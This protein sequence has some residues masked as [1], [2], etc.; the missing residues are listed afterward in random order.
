MINGFVPTAADEFTI[1]ETVV[2][3]SGSFANVASGQRLT[4]VDGLGSFLVNYGAGSPFDP[5]QIVLSSFLA[6]A[7][8][9]DYNHSGVVDAADYVIWRNGGSP[10]STQSGYNL[11]KTNF[12][13]TAGSG[14]AAKVNAAVPEATTLVLAV[15]G[16]LTLLSRRRDAVS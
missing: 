10:D 3:I 16:T 6:V 2:S 7:V 1:L 9:G 12:G 14:A 13:K 15:V 4:T 8:P 5:S 11:W